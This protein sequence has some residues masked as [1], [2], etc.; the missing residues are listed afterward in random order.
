V[1]EVDAVPIIDEE[2]GVDRP[3]SKSGDG[4]SCPVYVGDPFDEPGYFSGMGAAPCAVSDLVVLGLAGLLAKDEHRGPPPPCM[5]VLLA[6]CEAAHP[7]LLSP[8]QRIID[9]RRVRLQDA[10]SSTHPRSLF[11]A[12]N[13]PGC[14]NC[15]IGEATVAGFDH[16]PHPLLCVT[17]ANA[18]GFRTRGSRQMA[19]M[20][21]RLCRS[22]GPVDSV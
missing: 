3:P 6:V 21:C 19:L 9:E 15:L 16:C 20:H 12:G 18:G 7:C 1:R 2:A 10:S 8:M 11:L 22:A 14:V 17:C 4:E 13:P 5:D